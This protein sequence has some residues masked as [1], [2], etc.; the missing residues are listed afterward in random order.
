MLL[1][2]GGVFFLQLTDENNVAGVFRNSFQRT[3]FRNTRNL[4]KVLSENSNVFLSLRLSDQIS[5]AGV[6]S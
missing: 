3:V 2:K 5:V 4:R 6:S 1:E